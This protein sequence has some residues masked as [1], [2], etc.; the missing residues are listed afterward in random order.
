VTGLI[1]AG[2]SLMSLTDQTITGDVWE[3]KPFIHSSIQIGLTDLINSVYSGITDLD[4]NAA[5]LQSI[6]SSRRVVRLDEYGTRGYVRCFM[7]F[8]L[9]I[10]NCAL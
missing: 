4:G 10:K 1:A 7:E 3:Y 2:T 6:G 5:N 8:D 9:G